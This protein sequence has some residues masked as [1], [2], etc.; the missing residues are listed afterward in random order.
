[1][2]VISGTVNKIAEN[3]SFKKGTLNPNLML[4]LKISF[5]YQ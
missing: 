3:N 2:Q 1:M 5:Y 4:S